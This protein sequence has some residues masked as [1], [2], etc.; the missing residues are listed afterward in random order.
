MGHEPSFGACCTFAVLLCLSILSF[1]VRETSCQD[2]QDGTLLAKNFG[3]EV[4]KATVEKIQESGIFA[5]DNH[6]LRR[7][8]YV[9]SKDG[10]D[11]RTYRDG[12]HGGIW[13]VDEIAF[14]DTQATA[15][16]PLLVNKIAEIKKKFGIEWC[17]VEWTDLEK[18]L[19]SG[20]AARLFLSNNPE[21]IPSEMDEQARYWKEHYNTKEGKGT[22]QRF[23]DAVDELHGS[24]SGIES[25]TPRP[26][27]LP[28][29]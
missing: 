23:K 6:F 11:S 18:P 26:S 17:S 4:V 24:G 12:Y 21:P 13:Q 5:D 25:H 29:A 20:L 3:A 9:E 1:A 19:Y 14:K 16:H 10:T 22:E 7:V 2:K 8:A 28:N 27:R 15:S